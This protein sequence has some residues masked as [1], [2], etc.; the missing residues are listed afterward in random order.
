[1]S[2]G[3]AIFL[4]RDGVINEKLP[5]DQYVGCAEQFRL[6]PGVVD[7]LKIFQGLGYVLV[8]VTNQ[9]GVALRKIT[10]A[11]VL[12]VHEH[13]N[14][15]LRFQDIRIDCITHCPHDNNDPQCSCR[16]PKPGLILRTA[17]A[18][19]LDLGKSYMVGDSVSDIE[20]GRNAGIGV[21]VFIGAE[22][23]PQADLCFQGLL[24]FAEYLLRTQGSKTSMK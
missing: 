4:D 22:N 21:T 13:M 16:K 15:L 12:R 1:M 9:R 11:D 5:E 23:V 18:L 10:E 24:G 20:A 3:K 19:C 8:V 7:A 2:N 17:H 6:L 14:D